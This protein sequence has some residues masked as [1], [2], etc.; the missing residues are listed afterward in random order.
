MFGGM[1]MWKRNNGGTARRWAERFF[2]AIFL[3]GD[4][5]NR[6][7]RRAQGV[8]EVIRASRNGLLAVIFLVLF[9]R[10]AHA[11]VDP[12]SG[13]LL[14]QALVAGFFGFAFYAR[15]YWYRIVSRR[16]P[17]EDSVPKREDE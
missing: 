17:K 12:G 3:D 15:R 9:S 7:R 5:G 8:L 16:N 10:D 6:C 1:W 13:A 14:W 4:S 11:Y 2:S